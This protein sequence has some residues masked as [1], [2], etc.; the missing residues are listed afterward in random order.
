MAC[1]RVTFKFIIVQTKTRRY[2]YLCWDPRHK[3]GQWGQTRTC[4]SPPGRRAPGDGLMAL[5]PCPLLVACFG[6]SDLL[7]VPYLHRA[8]APALALPSISPALHNPSWLTLGL[9]LN[10][11]SSERSSLMPQ[12]PCV[13]LWSHSLGAQVSLSLL[14]PACCLFGVPPLHWTQSSSRTG[15]GVI[16]KSTVLAQRLAYEE[17]CGTTRTTGSGTR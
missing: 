2:E 6:F 14:S 8:P 11:P 15:P 1:E 10:V 12:P 13:L 7:P 4:A 17:Q 9:R 3:P 5:L 16:F